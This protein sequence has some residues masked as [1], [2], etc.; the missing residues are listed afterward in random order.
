MDTKHFVLFLSPGTFVSETREVEVPKHD[1]DNTIVLAQDIVE[2]YG[3]KPY[4]FQFITRERSDGWSVPKETYRSGTYYLGGTVRT[5]EQ[6]VED[7][8]PDE[9]ILRSNMRINN[10][11]RI[12][13]NNNSWKFTAEL[14]DR[15]VVLD[16]KL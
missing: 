14:K 11:E 10:I 6:V 15:D 4:G 8:R 9:E 13:E 2:R 1:V 12:I 3:A 16:V 5:Y 7:N